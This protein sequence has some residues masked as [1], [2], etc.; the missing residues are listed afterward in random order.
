MASASSPKSA[1]AKKRPELR[2]VTENISRIS[3]ARSLSD[4]GGGD[5]GQLVPSYLAPSSP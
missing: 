4:R 3:E 1:K 2:P 5:A